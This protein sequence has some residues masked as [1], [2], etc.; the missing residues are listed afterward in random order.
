[1]ATRDGT[2]RD[3]RLDFRDSDDRELEA[4]GLEGDDLIFGTNND[5][6]IDG[7]EDNDTIYGERGNDTLLGSSGDDEIYGRDGDDRLIGEEGRDTLSGDAG[8][9]TY[10]YRSIS[11]LRDDKIDFSVSE[12]DTIEINGVEF[13]IGTSDQDL[14][15]YDSGS[16]DLSFRG[17]RLAELPT[18]LDFRPSSDIV[19]I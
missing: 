14:F 19:I 10:F 8:S 16:G 7:G 5:D 1:M 11:D 15:S 12:G 2:R 3:D 18:G 6:V 13:G 9:D 4:Y 17:D